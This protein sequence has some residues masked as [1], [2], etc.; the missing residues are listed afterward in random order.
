M[1]IGQE[2]L[3]VTPLQ[4]LRM[5]AAIANGGEL[6]TPRVARRTGSSVVSEN[7]GSASSTDLLAAPRAMPIPEISPLV[8]QQVRQGLEQVVSN[9]HGTGYKTVRMKEVAIAGKSGTAEANGGPN[10]AWFAGYFPADRPRYSFVVVLERGGAGGKAA[11]PLAKQL[12]QS[13]LKAGLI[14]QSRQLT[15][16]K[17]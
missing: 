6:L 10:H 9:S 1:A 12:V 14:E 16:A 13:M 4:I 17:E 7:I 11:G 15:E 3:I 5:M 8:L 2:R